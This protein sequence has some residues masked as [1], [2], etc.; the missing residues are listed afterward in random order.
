VRLNVNR[1][2]IAVQYITQ[3]ISCYVRRAWVSE[4]I[5]TRPWIVVLELLIWG[6][7][8]CDMLGAQSLSSSRSTADVHCR[9]LIQVRCHKPTRVRTVQPVSLPRSPSKAGVANPLLG[10]IQTLLSTNDSSLSKTL[11]VILLVERHQRERSIWG[12]AKQGLILNGPQGR[13]VSFGGRVCEHP[14][15]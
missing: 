3:T 4:M 6:L 12:F 13:L 14:E 9:V 15:W 11:S 1:F 2:E 7:R 8:G 10:K 5:E